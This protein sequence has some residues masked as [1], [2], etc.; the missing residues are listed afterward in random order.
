ML[1]V[2][3][4]H[5]NGRI[6][7]SRRFDIQRGVKQGD[8]LSP[9]LFNAGVEAALRKWK[10]RVAGKGIYV[11]DEEALTNIRYADDIMLFATSLEDLLFMITALK[12]ELARIGLSLN[13]SKTKVLTTLNDIDC[14]SMV[15]VGEHVDILSGDTAHKYLGRKL[16]G[17]LRSRNIFELAHR[18][19]IAWMRFHKNRDILMDKHL[20]IYSRLKFF[21]AVITPT[22]L[23]GLT[24]CAMTK[25]QICSLDVVQRRMFRN[26]VGWV[27]HDGEPWDETMRRMRSKVEV[28]LRRCPIENWSTQLFRRQ[29]RLAHRVGNMVDSWPAR[30]C[31]WH[32]PTSIPGAKR[33]QGRPVV[34]WDDYLRKFA[35]EEFADDWYV[36]C[37]D[38]NFP[39]RENAFVH[40]SLN[41]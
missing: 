24:S 14:Q 32:P 38:N 31:K 41:I 25:S 1:S 36:A 30:V 27:R 2:I 10:I 40:F 3:Y 17:N 13:A 4:A 39:E 5:Q 19:Q 22:I 15:I 26:I 29:F 23:F 18:V 11:D 34:R 35:E 6:R 28:A 9:L 33:S 20:S 7:G 8:V 37:L 16:C 21:Q 12:E